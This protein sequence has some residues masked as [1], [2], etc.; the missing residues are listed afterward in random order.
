MR[1]SGAEPWNLQGFQSSPLSTQYSVLTTPACILLVPSSHESYLFD[2]RARKNL[3]EA[4]KQQTMFYDLNVPWTPNN[5]RE[6][7]RTVAFLDERKQQLPV[8]IA[9]RSSQPPCGERERRRE[10]TQVFLTETRSW[11]RCCR[12]HSH[13]IWKTSGR[14]GKY[15]LT[16]FRLP[17]RLPPSP[18]LF[19]P[20]CTCLSYS[21][22]P[23]LHASHGSRWCC[24][25]PLHKSRHLPK[26]CTAPI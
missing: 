15:K 20:V 22:P 21:V 5:D 1:G 13:T 19:P 26:H 11:L 9:L 18:F 7:Q 8:E 14:L 10:G 24:V 4:I 16:L 17:V 12:P 25:L 3:G 23:T 6:L 2:E